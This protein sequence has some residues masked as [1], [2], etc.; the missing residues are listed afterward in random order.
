[1]IHDLIPQM[2]NLRAH[3]LGWSGGPGTV[4]EDLPIYRSEVPHNLLNG[5]LRVRGM[6]FED[7]AE[8]AEKVLAG[9]PWRWWTGPDSDPGTGERLARRGYTR[10]GRMPV[11]A[12]DLTRMP[13][14]TTPAGLTVEP[15]TGPRGVE[16]YVNACRTAFGL[17]DELHEGR[18]DMI[19]LVGRM[20]GRVVATAAVVLSDGVAG[21]Y[22]IA[23][24]P[25]YRGRGIGAELTTAAMRI[26]R[27]HGVDVAT[28]QAS[29]MGEP[30]YRRLGFVEAGEVVL[31]RR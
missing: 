3:W 23:T 21:L 25:E 20:D 2:A 6:P 9:V 22:W 14:L 13:G 11:M 19:R 28:L 29:S 24:A 18:A 26:A 10:L 5:V 27:D 31:Y 17:P 7:A 8:Q 30:V 4:G 16:E 12:A 1:M 15:V